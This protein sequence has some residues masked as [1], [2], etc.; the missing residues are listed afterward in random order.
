M[1]I[2]GI[3]GG[4]GSGKSQVLSFMKDEYQA[5]ICQADHVAWQLQE[6]DERCYIE[7]VSHFGKTVLN[8]D[9]T[10][11]RKALGKIVFSNEEELQV[12]NQII[13]PAVKTK[14]QKMIETEQKNGTK[15]F[16][17]EAALLL[18]D[19][20][21]MICDEIWFIYAD[22][23]VRRRRLKENRMYSDEKIDAIMNSQ[24]SEVSFREQCQLVIDNSGEF[25][26]TCYQIR[27]AMNK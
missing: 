14:I 16:V 22:E 26:D 24:L 17:L 6:P 2:I 13:H 15:L 9:G 10:I 20:Y 5:Y 3:T 19:H 8:E 4:V 18:E 11:D 1:K 25:E 21:D 27:K 12:L 23:S 7:I